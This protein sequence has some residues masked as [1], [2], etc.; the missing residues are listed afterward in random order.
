MF[1]IFNLQWAHLQDLLKYIELKKCFLS[2]VT[3]KLTDASEIEVIGIFDVN[4]LQNV[5]ISKDKHLDFW[6]KSKARIRKKISKSKCW[7]INVLIN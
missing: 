5:D 4:L 6:F 1:I 7:S 3:M 2:S